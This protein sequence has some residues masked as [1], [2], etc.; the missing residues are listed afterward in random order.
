MAQKSQLFD[1]INLM[2]SNP[3]K[4]T[5]Q[6]NYVKGKEFFMMNRFFAIKFPIQAN[7]FNH[8]KMNTNEAVQIW[9]DMLSPQSTRTP[10]WIWQGLKGA[11]KK[12]AEKKKKTIINDD[13]LKFYCSKKQL[14][15]KDLDYAIKTLGQPFVEEL[16][17]I[18]NMIEEKVK[19]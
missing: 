6:A 9:C 13:T 3:K 11:K 7:F 12:K 14:S 15:R 4:F 2:F 5:A 10:G 19:K 18:Q 16:L 8:I 1:Q 17:Q